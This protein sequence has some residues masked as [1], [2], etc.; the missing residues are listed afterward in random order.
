MQ[1]KFWVIWLKNKF[2]RKIEKIHKICLT[3]EVKICIIVQVDFFVEYF[4][5][6][7]LVL[8]ILGG[9]VVPWLKLE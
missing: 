1:L 6:D 7:I 3:D 4:Y 2:S 8:T 5:L 9:R